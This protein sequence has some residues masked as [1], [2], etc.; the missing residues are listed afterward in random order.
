MP[1]HLIPQDKANHEA[2]GARVSMVASSLWLLGAALAHVP[3]LPALLVAALVA[4]LG[5]ALVGQLKEWHD[6]LMNRRAVA[7]GL[8]P[9]HGVEGADIVA[10]SYGGLS[11]AVPLFVVWLMASGGA[12]K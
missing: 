1:I 3:L 11:V 9:P 2:Y 8:P 5:A 10:T 6:A 12:V 4:A 7:A